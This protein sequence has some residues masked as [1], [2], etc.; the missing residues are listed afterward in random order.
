MLILFNWALP[1]TRTEQDGLF[2]R[3]LRIWSSLR[4]GLPCGLYIWCPLLLLLIFLISRCSPL[5]IL[6]LYCLSAS[7]NSFVTDTSRLSTDDEFNECIDLF[8]L[9]NFF[10]ILIA[11]VSML[12][13]LI[14]PCPDLTST[15]QSEYLLFKLLLLF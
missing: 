6:P 15:S 5:I 4:S 2:L 11:L 14:C 3:Y 1:E 12:D 8:S 9:V 10:L 7:N 13:K